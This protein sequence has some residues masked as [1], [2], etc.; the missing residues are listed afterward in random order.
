MPEGDT[1]HRAA[2]SLRPVLVG[3]PLVR[4][5][6]PR[7]AHAMP[8]AGETT[9][10]VEARGKHLLMWFSGGLILHTHMQMT[11]SWHVYP[12][13]AQWRKSP[14]SARAVLETGEAVAVC[15]AAPIV[16]L[17][18]ERLLRRH[19]VLREL[20]PDL[21]TEGPDIDL[22]LTRLAALPPTTILADALLDQRV[23]CGVGNVYKS[24]VAFLHG[25]HPATPIGSIPTEA[26]R[27]MLETAS[28]LLTQNLTKTSRTTVPG[29]PDGA[30]WVYDRKDQP[31]RRCSTSIAWSPM[32][33]HDRGT[34]WCPTCQPTPTARNPD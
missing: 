2:A 9:D 28:E 26:R 4:A 10:R 31:C 21:T 29:A 16:E 6:A 22:A 13:G 23:A 18:D 12:R 24:E 20:G 8:D 33:R 30:V 17:L 3:I 34:Y 7:L 15:F 27:A 32:G 14:R 11:G 5:S 1:I 19:P 25:L